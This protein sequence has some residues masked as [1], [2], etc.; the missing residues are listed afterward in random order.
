MPTTTTSTAMHPRMLKRALANAPARQERL[1]VVLENFRGI[2]LARIQEAID[3]LT[4][5]SA[6]P[7]CRHIGT[8]IPDYEAVRKALEGIDPAIPPTR[9]MIDRLV[10]QLEDLN[11][12][13]KTYSEAL[14]APLAEHAS[15]AIEE[16]PSLPEKTISNPDD[17]IPICGEPGS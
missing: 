12:T 16:G 2:A 9:E 15:E 5:L 7:G 10:A 8:L 11:A 6:A 13:F 17:A 1:A 14:V 4:R 3:V